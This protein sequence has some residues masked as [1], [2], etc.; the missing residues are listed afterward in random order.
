MT[1]RYTI[2]AVA[3]AAARA[4]EP[5]W[6]TERR[7]EAFERFTSLPWPEPSEE[8]WRHTDIRKLDFD[9]FDPQPE[10]NA[11]VEGLESLPEHIRRNAI[12][13]KGDRLG[14]Q[15]CI[16]ADEV[17]LRLAPSLREQGVVF[18]QLYRVADEH[19]DIVERYFGAAGI[20]ESE[21]KLQALNA[22]FSTSATLLYV[23]RGVQIELPIQ[24]IRWISSPNV[25]V[26][27]RLLLVAGEGAEVTYIDY[28]ASQTLG[29]P[30]LAVPVVEIFAEQGA[31]VNYLGVQDWSQDVNHLAT[32]RAIGGRDSTIR[33]LAATLGGKLSRTVTHG[34]LDGQGAHAEMLG[35]FFGDHDQHIDNRTLQAH[36]APYTSSELYYKG[37]LKGTSRAVYSGLVDIDKDGVMADAQ[38]ACRNL[39]LSDG[40]SADPSPF[41]EIKTSE[42]AR[43]TS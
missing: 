24:V 34:L 41:L 6:M 5:A 22:A 2:D 1:E 42:V 10:A 31:I 27:P 13:Q 20:A 37:A 14:L 15:V 43:A 25:G 11:P 39:L 35:L 33:T 26:F 40:A 9:W 23:P 18:E 21:Q 19:R 29:G 32:S 4:Q 28:F 7:N 38:Q 3:R 16:D 36:R 30:S 12:G 8:A 17:H